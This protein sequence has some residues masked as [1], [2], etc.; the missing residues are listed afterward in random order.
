MGFLDKARDKG[1][2]KFQAKLQSH[3][4]PGEQVITTI[5]GVMRKEVSKGGMDKSYSGSLALTNQRVIYIGSFGLEKKFDSHPLA[6]LTGITTTHGLVM[7][8][9]EIKNGLMLQE[10]SIARRFMD[11]FVAEVRRVAD[12]AQVQTH[13]APPPPPAPPSASA[14]DELK[15]LA[16]LHAQGILDDDEFAEAKQRIIDSM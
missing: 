7:G 3:L 12:S 4:N 8:E 16:D 9:L 15:K 5:G 13:S 1:Q 2:A 6:T 11:D 10:Y 14:T